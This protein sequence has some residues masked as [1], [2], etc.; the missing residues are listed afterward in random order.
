[1]RTNRLIP[2]LLLSL[3]LLCSCGQ[4]EPA[5]D[6][7]DSSPSQETLSPQPDVSQNPGGL[8]LVDLLDM[9]VADVT[10]L[11][12]EDLNY[13]EGWYFGASKYFNYADYRVPYH[14]SFLDEA[15]TGTASGSEAISTVTYLPQQG[16]IVL[17]AP[18]IPA[19]ATYPQLKEQGL[20]GTFSTEIG[21][22]DEFHQGAAAYFDCDYSDT[23]GLTF[24]WSEGLDPAQDPADSITAVRVDTQASSDGSSASSGGQT[25]GDTTPTDA[26]PDPIPEGVGGA[27]QGFTGVMGCR[28]FIPQGFTQDNIRPAVGYLYQYSDS[29]R[30]M[31]ISISECALIALPT[32]PEEDYFNALASSSRQ[33]TYSFQEDGRYVLSGNTGDQIFYEA[34]YYNDS[35]RC[36]VS[37]LYPQA[38]ADICNTIVEEFMAGFS[39]F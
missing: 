33:V 19:S 39:A 8:Y 31:T 28:F 29:G 15:R 12:G 23:V 26:I 32:T 34:V 18:D 11:W 30:G 21:P 38:N 6:P 13:M 16:T 7:A 36:E 5:E 10:A 37:F 20:E 22:G 3:L 2:A 35:N 9:T 24:L 25:Q 1:M 17:V 4:Q 27:P 14:F